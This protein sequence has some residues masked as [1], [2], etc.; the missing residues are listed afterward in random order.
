MAEA[1]T[2]R[3][4]FDTADRGDI[5]GY[6]GWVG[7]TAEPLGI[8][9][10][11]ATTPAG[12]AP[13]YAR[14]ETSWLSAD[15]VESDVR[16]VIDG[17]A[18]TKGITIAIGSGGADNAAATIGFGVRIVETNGVW[19]IARVTD[20]RALLAAS[21][22]VVVATVFPAQD[23]GVA[24]GVVQACRVRW[25][26][27]LS[28]IRVTAWWGTAPE[29]EP[30]FDH[31]YQ[32]SW[33]SGLTATRGFLLLGC[34]NGGG[35]E[36]RCLGLEVEAARP[37]QDRTPQ[38]AQFAS[39]D[40]IIGRALRKFEGRRESPSFPA[41][42]LLQ[43][44]QEAQDAV[45]TLLGNF[46]WFNRRVADMVLVADENGRVTMPHGVDDV[47]VI[48][49]RGCGGHIAW[50]TL[51]HTE[52]GRVLVRLENLGGVDAT[53]TYA[54]RRERL[55]ANGNVAVHRD[56]DRALVDQLVVGMAE[57]H[58]S[59][60]DYQKRMATAAK[61]MGDALTRCQQ[62]AQS[63]HAAMVPVWSR[64]GRRNRPYRGGF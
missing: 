29:S 60:E 1:L 54:P 55:T 6:N 64:G 53:V 63:A 24:T 43:L 56:I 31:T 48:E 25:R 40:E 5:T 59:A 62:R 14:Q 45:L 41:D 50:R 9:A 47:L 4:Q 21:T 15:D 26:E 12:S 30:A 22:W 11:A 23:A 51:G 61:S 18:G 42:R 39:V 35:N 7:R 38:L 8:V 2:F 27:T 36:M 28:G 13:A 44:L 20:P 52:D 49:P 33:P 19:N 37:A 46:A 17:T 10:Q 58:S 34:D 32:A 16:V 57:S 3:E